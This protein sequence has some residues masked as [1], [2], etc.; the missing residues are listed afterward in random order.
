MLRRL[1]LWLVISTCIVAING[2]VTH[3]ADT[4]NQGLYISPV[5]TY[6]SGA[7][8]ETLTRS[9]TV[10]NKTNQPMTVQAHVEQFSVEDYSYNFIFTHT[11]NTWVQTEQNAIALAPYQAHELVYTVTLPKAAMPGG[12]YY[13]LYVAATSPA[14]ESTTLQTGMMLYLTVKGQLTYTSSASQPALP[15]FVTSPAISYALT[16]KNT[17]NTHYFVYTSTAIDGILYHDA[18]N[19]TS[20]LLMPGTTRQITASIRSPLLPGIYRLT[21]NIKP[22]NGATTTGSR[23]FVYLPLW[24]IIGICLCLGVLWRLWLRRQSKRPIPNA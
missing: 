16:V 14:G 2:S 1:S 13:T 17:G 15:Y 23:Y 3:A 24:S 21:Y 20:Q 22:D 12:Y 9:F 7:P 5:R 8:G 4:K 19:G 10:A 11:D 6:L 18:P